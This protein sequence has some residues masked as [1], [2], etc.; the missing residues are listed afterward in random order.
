M[1][2][3]PKGISPDYWYLH[4]GWRIAQPM[5][6]MGNGAYS[7]L[8][9]CFCRRSWTN[10]YGRDRGG[11]KDKPGLLPCPLCCPWLKVGKNLGDLQNRIPIAGG[12]WNAKEL[13]D[14]AEVTD[15]F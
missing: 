7:E 2:A 5:T 3:Q 4:N 1:S 13:L 15:R 12:G 9:A 11:R 8:P 14:L 10:R 6:L